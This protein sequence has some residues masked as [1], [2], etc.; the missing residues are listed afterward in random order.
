MFIKRSCKCENNIRAFHFINWYT[1]IFYMSFSFNINFSFIITPAAAIA[2]QTAVTWIRIFA[3]LFGFNFVC[4]VFIRFCFKFWMTPFHSSILKPNFHLNFIK[5]KKKIIVLM[6]FL[7]VIFTQIE[8]EMVRA[9]RILVHRLILNVRPIFCDL[10]SLCTSVFE[11][12]SPNLCAVID[13]KRHATTIVCVLLVDLE[14]CM[15]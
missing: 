2:C 3:T 10:V 13:W 8:I 6:F 4:S 14:M 9:S 11:I 12:E 7:F 5:W 15:C 1:Y